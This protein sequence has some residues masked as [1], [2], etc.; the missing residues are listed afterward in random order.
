VIVAERADS[1]GDQVW[2]QG[3]LTHMERLK[4]RRVRLCPE[5]REPNWAAIYARAA[6]DFLKKAGKAALTYMSFGAYA[7]L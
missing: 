4:Q 2:L 3:T 5:Y 1:R 6:A 7:P